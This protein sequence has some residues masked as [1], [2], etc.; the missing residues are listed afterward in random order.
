MVGILKQGIKNILVLAEY[1]IYHSD[2]KPANF[3]LKNCLHNHYD[4]MII[5]IG[6]AS[7]E[8]SNIN[9]YTFRYLMETGNIDMFLNGP[10]FNSKF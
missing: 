4:V 3:A 10:T 7:F 5:D 8:W 6:S 1:D 9:A 2:Y